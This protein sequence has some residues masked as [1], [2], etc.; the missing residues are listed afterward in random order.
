MDKIDV[1]NKTIGKCRNQKNG[2]GLQK[3]TK[4]KDW[5]PQHFNSMGRLKN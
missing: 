4:I 1:K 5:S 2:L 3:T